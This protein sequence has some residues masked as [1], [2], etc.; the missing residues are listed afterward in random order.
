MNIRCSRLLR[1]IPIVVTY[2]FFVL[3]LHVARV[4]DGSLLP[5][6]SLRTTW[7][8]VA[9]LAGLGVIGFISRM[10]VRAK[11]LADDNP[12]VL[13]IQ[14]FYLLSLYP[15]A[16]FVFHPLGVP[17][18]FSTLLQPDILLLLA[19]CLFVVRLVFLAIPITQTFQ[20]LGGVLRARNHAQLAFL[21]FLGFLSLYG[22]LIKKEDRILMLVGDEPHYMIMMESMRR[23]QTAD[24]TKILESND[25]LPKGVRKLRPH[26][27]IM[28]APGT[29]YEVHNIGISLMMIPGYS[30]VGYKGAVGTFGF[31]AALLVANMFLLGVETTGRKWTS[32]VVAVLAGLSAPFIFY[33]RY[34]YPEMPAALCLIYAVR[35]LQR[36]K[37]TTGALLLA[38]AGAA[39]MPWFHVKFVIMAAILAGF[40]VL[41]HFRT[42]K[43]VVW[44]ALPHIPSALILM[45]FFYHAYGSWMPNAQYGDAH[46]PVSKFFFR[47]ALGL[48]LDRDHGLLAFAPLYW[49]AL[50]G[51]F[52]LFREN[53]NYTILALVLS[54]PSFAILASH[55]MWWGGPC[56]PARF[57][58]PLIPLFIP[59][60]I[61]ALAA[62]STSTF[63]LLAGGSILFT[64]ALS[65]VS[66][67]ELNSLPFH[68]H[69]LRWWVISYDAFP[70]F[71]L[72][73]IHRVDG[74]PRENF[75]VAALWILAWFASLL[76]LRRADG[77]HDQSFMTT[78]LRAPA[79]SIMAA[80]SLMLLTPGIIGY[81]NARLSGVNMEHPSG[82]TLPIAHM[83]VVL[84][85]YARPFVRAGVSTEAAAGRVAPYVLYS[86]QLLEAGRSY[87][88][89]ELD[90]ETRERSW[91]FFGKYTT[92]YPVDYLFTFTGQI[93]TEA[94]G[95]L[96]LF[97]ICH[98]LGRN[99]LWEN[100]M[101]A[102]DVE[103][104]RLSFSLPF[105]PDGIK[106]NAEFRA[107]ALAP[108]HYRFDQ[109]GLKAS[110]P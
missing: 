69:F 106:E 24:L 104:A 14:P 36:E 49:L 51:L 19:G 74:V 105:R 88:Q 50:P 31:L 96:V 56:P 43:S 100:T 53:R 102:M 87:T 32:L 17:L 85:N 94:D 22:I 42:I 11:S 68:R 10:M 21:L 52:L 12:F 66:L 76:L 78:L 91:I 27:S 30:L 108:G 41:R 99:I 38:G 9:G 107:A 4:P 33:F 77:A 109:V 90:T 89:Q 28:T 46:D 98:D 47:G 92:L 18:P 61:A 16:V 39:F 70:F 62:A 6:F 80:G 81:V 23:Y 26:A 2:L 57:I 75:V 1:I 73:F 72:F 25:P 7:L 97:D 79:R 48:L 103:E 45:V 34:L 84:D 110:I 40:C 60:V 59:A 64:L 35:V 8:L 37:P 86:R 15:L 3:S 20:K 65:V 67:G 44:Y 5:V 82:A 95:N 58:I 13:L 101:S 54:V 71:P 93:T 29:L 63:R 83:N 55:W